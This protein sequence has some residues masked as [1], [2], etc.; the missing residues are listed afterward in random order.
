MPAARILSFGTV[1]DSTPLARPG[2]AR[3]RDTASALDE[4]ALALAAA[5]LEQAAALPRPGT[6]ANATQNARARRN[7]LKLLKL[8]SVGLLACGCSAAPGAVSAIATPGAPLRVAVAAEIPQAGRLMPESRRAAPQPA[9]F[10]SFCMRFA[11][12]CRIRRARRRGVTLDGGAVAGPG[13]GQCTRQWR[14]T[15]DG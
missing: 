6:P 11:D 7:G 3:S 14:H 9:G 5:L 1:T 12:Q 4:V 8:L 13:T 10:I 15:P 2:A